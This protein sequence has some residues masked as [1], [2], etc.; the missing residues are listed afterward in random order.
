ML[1]SLCALCLVVVAAS[2]GLLGCKQLPITCASFPAPSGHFNLLSL[3]PPQFAGEQSRKIKYRE[4]SKNDVAVKTALAAIGECYSNNPHPQYKDDL[5]YMTYS[6][7]VIGP[8]QDYYIMYEFEN[9]TDVRVIFHV[10]RYG[11]VLRSM[12]GGMV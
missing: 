5:K 11:N 7:A 10:D 3:Y 6:D 4:A 2:T 12:T 1:R 8:D 9:I